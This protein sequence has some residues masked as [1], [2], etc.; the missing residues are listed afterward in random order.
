[1]AI[2]DGFERRLE[3]G[4]RVTPVIFAVSIRLAMRAQAAAPSSWPANNAFLRFSAS[5]RIVF[6]TTLESISTRPSV[7]NT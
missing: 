2:G 1:M 7:R 5:G 3:I 4:M 6:S